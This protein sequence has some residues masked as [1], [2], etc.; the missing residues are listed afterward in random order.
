MNEGSTTASAKVLI[1]YRARR[2]LNALS[3][4]FKRKSKDTI[5]RNANAKKGNRGRLTATLLSGFIL[6]QSGFQSH[7]IIQKIDQ[8]LGHSEVIE[9]QPDLFPAWNCA[10]SEYQLKKESIECSPLPKTGATLVSE[11]VKKAIALALL[12]LFITTFLLNIASKEL[13]TPEWDFEWLVTLPIPLSKLISVRFV[14]RTFV[15][16]SG[17]LLIWPFI[18]MLLWSAGLG[19]SS[20]LIGLG[21]ALILL[22]FEASLRTIVDTGMRMVIP[23][24][25]LRNFQAVTS[26]I[27]SASLLVVLSI[28]MSEKPVLL[29][30]SVSPGLNWVD[31]TPM[32]LIT[33]AV[34]AGSVAGAMKGVALLGLQIIF[35]YVLALKLLLHWLRFGIVA[36]GSRE[37]VKRRILSTA[38]TTPTD[39]SRKSILSPL[40]FRELK[41][42]MRDR[43]FMVQTLVLPIFI[44][45]LQF[46]F[47]RTSD[48]REMFQGSFSRLAATA[49]GAAAYSLIFSAF[50]VLN[51]EGKSL[52][53]LYT[54]PNRLENLLREKVLLW[55]GVALMYPVVLFGIGVYVTGLPSLESLVLIAIVL[56]GILIYGT[57]AAC[58]GV[59]ASDPLAEDP[60]H[61]SR[62]DYTYLYMI[63]AGF[64]TYAIFAKSYWD[65]FALL[66]LSALMALAL[67]QKARDHLPYL[68]DPTESPK[69][70]VSL[71][72]GLIA[73]LLFFVIQGI[74]TFFLALKSKALTG[75]DLLIAFSV[76]GA[77]TFSALRIIYWRKKTSGVPNV[78]GEGLPR[79]I[80]YGLASGVFAGSIGFGYIKLVSHY[81]FFGESLE[82]SGTNPVS[83]GWWLFALAVVAAPLFEEFIFRGIIFKGLLRTWA[84]PT[85][86]LASAGIFA[87]VHPPVSFIPVFSLAVIAAFGYAKT[88]LLI[89]P[90]IAHAVYNFIVLTLR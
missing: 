33:E 46:F 10:K 52:W 84:L 66:I 62:L 54:F 9:G 72:D 42:L 45:G 75:T 48:W 50:Q 25:T 14:E 67:F 86:A 2:F 47:S 23:P 38:Q 73:A 79:A 55:L 78:F 58:F 44:T 41:L 34:T 80:G 40:Q 64:Y 32:G 70:N 90:I 56:I 59:F 85:A 27:A 11:P 49:F 43:N 1:K 28:T 8:I 3:A 5:Q 35:A 15:N 83:G 18:T 29:S 63:L 61:R 20:V 57:V 30:W 51:A 53:M 82:N 26:L 88:R 13:T 7:Q 12:F 65:K 31:W 76:A 71:A 37:G 6:F 60:R 68:L 69:S 81:G 16:P 87:I 19:Y 74:S 21:S 77:I 89:T 39:V 36:G 22:F 17:L 24:S 4:G